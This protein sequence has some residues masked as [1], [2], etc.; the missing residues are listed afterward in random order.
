MGKVSLSQTVVKQLKLRSLPVYEKKLSSGH[1]Y[2]RRKTTEYS[3]RSG[4]KIIN[5]YVQPPSIS[6]SRVFIILC[7]AFRCTM[8]TAVFRSATL[9][10]LF[11]GHVL[12]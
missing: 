8:E 6:S 1:D 2:Y 4:R 3:E 10:R 11:E 12:R 7:H 5:D 9:V